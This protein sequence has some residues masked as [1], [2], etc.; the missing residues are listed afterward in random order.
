MPFGLHDAEGINL[1]GLQQR[2]EKR[3]SWISEAGRGDFQVFAKDSEG[4]D[5]GLG[6]GGVSVGLSPED[7]SEGLGEGCTHAEIDFRKRLGG[8]HVFMSMKGMAEEDASVL[9]G[10][11]GLFPGQ[12]WMI[13]NAGVM[14]GSGM[15]E[16]S[17][18]HPQSA[19]PTREGGSGIGIITSPMGYSN[20]G[21]GLGNVAMSTLGLENISPSIISLPHACVCSPTASLA[22]LGDMGGMLT[23]VEDY[24]IESWRDAQS[25]SGSA[26]GSLLP[27]SPVNGISPKMLGGFAGEFSQPA[28]YGPYPDVITHQSPISAT[29]ASATSQMPSYHTPG[30]VNTPAQYFGW[31]AAPPP[32]L[33]PGHTRNTCGGEYSEGGG[34]GGRVLIGGASAKIPEDRQRQRVVQACEKCRERKAAVS[35]VVFSALLTG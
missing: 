6:L 27:V 35:A 34:D 20:A 15:R 30:N 22:Q 23:R 21:L 2:R 16:D 29:A 8:S 4:F 32:M 9:I 10:I 7:L 24:S 25:S 5:V 33:A 31:D 11:S 13:R 1:A 3:S 26:S 17:S 19:S 28:T 18:G 12:S 14:M